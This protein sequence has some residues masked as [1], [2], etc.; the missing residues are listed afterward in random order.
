[1]SDIDYKK[2][3]TNISSLIKLLNKMGVKTISSCSG[4]LEESDTG[5]YIY[6]DFT[7]ERLGFFNKIIKEV[8]DLSIKNHPVPMGREGDKCLFHH[9]MEVSM[10]IRQVV[11]EHDENMLVLR[12]G[13]IEN[14][15]FT[16]D[17]FYRMLFDVVVRIYHEQI[18]LT[19]EM[20]YSINTFNKHSELDS[21]Y[22]IELGGIHSRR[23]VL[24][25]LRKDFNWSLNVR[26]ATSE[27]FET[28]KALVKTLDVLLKEMDE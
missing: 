10:S 27:W 16:T 19:P 4:H 7:P 24:E 11:D 2:I 18:G 5:G 1:M 21:M 25:L 6:V 3:D 14:P 23:S 13:L 15:D 28:V 12:W 9:Q 8:D 22:I 26:S 20:M 17:A